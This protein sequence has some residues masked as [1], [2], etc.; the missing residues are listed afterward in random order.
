M[1]LDLSEFKYITARTQS[2]TICKLHNVEI[3][4]TA[5]D[6]MQGIKK[7]KQ[8]KSDAISHAQSYTQ[9]DF[10]KKAHQAHGSRYDYT[11]STWIDSK[12]AVGIT[13]RLHGKFFQNPQSH[14]NGYGCPQCG[15]SKVRKSIS[16]FISD[17]NAVHMNR[18]SYENADYINNYTPVKIT[19]SEH[20]IFE[21][22]PRSH[23]IYK[24]GCPACFPGNK[25]W[26]EISWLNELNVPHDC[27]QK[28]IHINGKRFL[29]DAKINN[30]V[31][32]FWGDFWH[33]NP[34]KFRLDDKN[35]KCNKTFRELY[36]QTMEKRKLILDA[37][38]DLV[39]VWESD[40]LKKK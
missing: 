3:Q 9:A 40:Y 6:L 13:C 33:G 23:L 10:L 31:Y 7:C 36:E 15:Y 30:T 22:S 24:R 16:T 29:V 19:C 14:W 32:E 1:D 34:S 25:S 39:E 17:A 26:P 28:S 8:C 38:F 20:G 2:T 37:G 12:T 21:L 35:T 27:R 5:N 11:D 4:N 18:Y